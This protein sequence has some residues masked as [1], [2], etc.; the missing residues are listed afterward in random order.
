MYEELH[1]D[2]VLMDILMP[3]MDGFDAATRIKR[4]SSDVYTPLIYVTALHP[5]EAMKKAVD[6]GCDDFVTKPI[7]FEILISKINA[8][9]R[10][11]EAYEKLAE[12]NE[13]LTKH[14]QRLTRE[15][16]IVEHIF[17]N[18]LGNS[19]LDERFIR[20]HMTSVSAFNGD[21]L[22]VDRKPDGN[23][24]VLL[25]D[26]TGHGLAA[27][28]G[29][30]PA[31]KVFF[32]M[33]KKG[34]PLE[35]IVA[36]L[37]ATMKMLLPTNMFLCA[38]L[39]ELDGNNGSVAVWSGG[40]PPL[41]VFNAASEELK[42]VKGDYMPLGIVEP[43]SLVTE[44]TRLQLQKGDRIYVYTDGI[45]DARNS[46][47]EIYGQ[48]RLEEAVRDGGERAFERILEDHMAYMER[49]E[50]ADDTSLVELNCDELP[51]A[52]AGSIE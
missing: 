1:P 20:Y 17:N 40:L 34:M 23:I 7:K 38:S 50:N 28:V 52:G 48:V 31:V 10:I 21:I 5:E 25:G 35:E 39:I 12:A 18:A 11:K 27:A 44:L 46:Q 36:E 2:L 22:L 6:A 3:D 13:E 51:L 33:V 24:C 26:F 43:D 47:G 45:P 41:M 4:I 37:N 16:E 29:S 19:F 14:N 32:T 9:L 49:S 42:Q 30:L 8:H 15:H